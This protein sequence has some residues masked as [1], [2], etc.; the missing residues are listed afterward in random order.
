MKNEEWKKGTQL[1]SYSSGVCGKSVRFDISKS[2][3]GRQELGFS[4]VL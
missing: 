3:T 1:G 2:E 4:G